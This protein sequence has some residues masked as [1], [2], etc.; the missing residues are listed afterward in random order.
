MK[1]SKNTPGSGT[2][3][4]TVEGGSHGVMRF[5]DIPLRIVSL[6]NGGYLIA[7]RPGADIRYTL[8]GSPSYIKLWRVLAH[9]DKYH[10]LTAVGDHEYWTAVDERAVNLERYREGDKEQEWIVVDAGD[11]VV[12]IEKYTDGRFK[13]LTVN[14]TVVEGSAVYLE[15]R[16]TALKQNQKFRLVV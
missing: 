1:N 8:V 9:G 2:S 14:P 16:E 15:Y 4:Q 11:G 7:S 12:G 3:D 10:I 5:P 13:C 6:V